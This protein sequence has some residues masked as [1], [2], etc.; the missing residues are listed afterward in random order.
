MRRR[1]HICRD[2]H[3]GRCPLARRNSSLVGQRFGRL[4]VIAATEQRSSRKIVYLC[5]CD[6]GSECRVPSGRLSG[7]LQVSCGC[8][9]SDPEIRRAA[10][11]KVPRRERKRIAGSGGDAHRI[12]SGGKWRKLFEERAKAW[13]LADRAPSK[14]PCGH[15]VPLYDCARCRKA[16]V[17]WACTREHQ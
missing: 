17:L 1:C 13:C 9:K 5:R 7:E 2:I 11:A 3:S 6:C 8:A 15:L 14:M 16:I 4:L 12:A 10:R